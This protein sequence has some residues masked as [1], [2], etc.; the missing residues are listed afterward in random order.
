M[1]NFVDAMKGVNHAYNLCSWTAALGLKAWR[2]K[3]LNTLPDMF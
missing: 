2:I 3:E 1:H